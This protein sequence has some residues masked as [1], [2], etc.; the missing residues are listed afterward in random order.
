MCEWTLLETGI[1]S[2]FGAMIGYMDVKFISNMLAFNENAWMLIYSPGVCSRC[3][4]YP[5][6]RSIPTKESGA[7]IMR[8]LI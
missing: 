8:N 1:Y 7:K 4:S 3:S 5:L 6:A 2:F